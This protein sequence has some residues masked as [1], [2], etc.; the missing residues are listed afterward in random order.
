MHG[1]ALRTPK[2]AQMRSWTDTI[3]KSKPQPRCHSPTERSEVK[4]LSASA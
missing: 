3:T 2:L 1:V 4:N